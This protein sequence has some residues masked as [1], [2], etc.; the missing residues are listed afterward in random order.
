MRVEDARAAGVAWV[1]QHEAG[2]GWFRGA[3]FTGST[4]TSEMTAEQPAWSDIDVVVVTDGRPAG[5]KV[6]KVAHDGALVEVTHLPWEELADPGRVPRTTW[7]PAS[8][9]A[10]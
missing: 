9:A 4:T 5:P 3:F 1:L 6:G 2:A 10:R 8:P 7:H